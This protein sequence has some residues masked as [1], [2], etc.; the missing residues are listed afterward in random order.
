MRI[1]VFHHLIEPETDSLVRIERLLDQVL[2]R[3]T[4]QEQIIMADLSAISAAVATN[5]SVVDSA[6]VLLNDIAAQFA[7]AAT[8]PAAVAALAAE[9][10]AKSADLAAAIVA[11]TPAA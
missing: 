7:A 10:E 6:I 9:I 5:G 8:D 2:T 3:L 4:Q 11:N 1:D